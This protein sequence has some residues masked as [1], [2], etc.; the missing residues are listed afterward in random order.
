MNITS[1]K[2]SVNTNT[3]TV[4]EFLSQAS[5]IEKLLPTDQISDFQSN[6]EGCSFKVQ[7]GFTIPLIYVDKV[8]NSRIDMKSGEKA[9]F[10]YTL[11]ILLAEDG[12]TSVGHIEFNADINLFM[13]MM[14]EKQ[15]GR[16][17]V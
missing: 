8:A 16:A 1:E 17:H 13:K 14:V 7:G 9:P 12:S 5:N 15:I 2:A 3:Q 11:S 6:D 4:F 10:K